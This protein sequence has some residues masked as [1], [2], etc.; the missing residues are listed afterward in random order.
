MAGVTCPDGSGQAPAT[1]GRHG[2]TLPLAWLLVALLHLLAGWWLVGQM[3]VALPTPPATPVMHVQ[4]LNASPAAPVPTPPAPAVSQARRQPVVPVPVQPAQPAP[5]P[6]VTEPV[7]TVPAEGGP[8]PSL[9]AAAPAEDAALP[10]T[11]PPTVNPA[12]GSRPPTVY[13]AVSRRLGEQGEV[14]LGLH[15]LADGRIGEVEVRR[16]SGHPRLDRAAIDAARRW[17]LL[18]ASRGGQP[19]ALWHEWVVVFRLH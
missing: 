15:V 1:R 14:V 3:P 4:L 19:V 2:G 7:P 17:R 16:S 8:A 5:G 12:W 18:P 6:A 9:A 11:L 13:P 10:D